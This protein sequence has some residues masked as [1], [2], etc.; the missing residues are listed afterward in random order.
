MKGAEASRALVDLHVHFHRSFDEVRFF[1][2]ATANFADAA[3]HLKIETPWTGI[4]VLTEGGGSSEFRRFSSRISEPQSGPIIFEATG[5][6]VSISVRD[7]EA[8][9]SGSEGGGQDG[10]GQDGGDQPR[11]VVVA[12]RQIQTH[13]GLE[14]LAFPLLKPIPDG[15]SLE[16][17]LAAAREMGV[18]PVLPWGFGKWSAGRGRRLEDF[19]RREGFRG[20]LLSDT[21]HRPRCTPVPRFLRLGGAASMPILTGSDPLPLPGEDRRPGSFCFSLPDD[22]WSRTPGQILKRALDT[23]SSSPPRFERPPG[24]VRFVYGQIA[25]Q[26]KKRT[27]WWPS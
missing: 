19:L 17:T 2:S 6:P 23:L 24:L 4:L 11:L 1:R 27:R 21:G 7:S 3:R 12:G 14:V 25:M 18:V 5:E 13:E 16:R 20:I 22:D 10:G 8:T 15:L 9:I 26:V